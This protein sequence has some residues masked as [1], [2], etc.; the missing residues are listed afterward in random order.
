[1]VTT[2][3]TLS[4]RVVG[5]DHHM[6]PKTFQDAITITRKLGYRYIWIDS[7]CIVQDSQHDWQRE[8]SLM[9]E[10]YGSA[11]LTISAASA[12]GD[13]VGF[14]RTRTPD[15]LPPV[16]LIM[17]LPNGETGTAFVALEPKQGAILSAF[18]RNVERSIINTRAWM[19]QERALSPRVLHYGEEQM[20]WECASFELSEDGCQRSRFA[21]LQRGFGANFWLT[22]R[23]YSSHSI[24]DEGSKHKE[25]ML[26]YEWQGLVQEYTKRKLTKPSDKLPAISG[27]AHHASA[28]F[29]TKYCVGMW[30][31]GIQHA[32]DWLV[33]EPSEPIDEYRAPS[34]S[35][36]AVEGPISFI[37][38]RTL[39]EKRPIFDIENVV[40]ELLGED[41][42]GQVKTGALSL[43]GYLLPAISTQ[44][45]YFYG[46]MDA[47]E[48]GA[49]LVEPTRALGLRFEVLDK[50]D[51]LL[52]WCGWDTNGPSP[53]ELSCLVLY[54]CIDRWGEKIYSTIFLEE[55]DSKSAL[56][57]YRR[58]GRGTVW[59]FNVAEMSKQTL[60]I[61]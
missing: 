11:H 4:E 6:L 42:Y 3:S 8:A 27:L 30:Q 38:E 43:H 24:D 10:Y 51:K 12:I 13:H 18:Y 15:A 58:V 31:S 7:L 21:G 57:R 61:V 53:K 36:A 44:K 28:A 54:Q 9:G 49:T 46:D 55:V 20:C 29:G 60:V 2:S 39:A 32:L 59:D 33:Q 1:M 17:T 48:T 56:P 41:K 14:L 37:D 5:I 35:W 50:A 52:G 22:D 23:Q 26:R 25:N 40:V 16:S 47:D 19:L 34:W 45:P